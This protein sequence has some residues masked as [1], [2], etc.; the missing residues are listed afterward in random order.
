MG[1]LAALFAASVGILSTTGDRI[2]FAIEVAPP[3]PGD[4]LYAAASEQVYVALG[5]LIGAVA[6]PLQAASRTL[7]VRVAPPQK[8]TEF[9]GLYA[10]AGKVTSFLGPTA[11]GAVTAWTMSQRAGMAVLLVFFGLGAVLLAMVRVPPARAQ[12]AVEA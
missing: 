4:G 2:F 9:F 12:G 10:L 5:L 11:V 8:I 1:T 6:G 3:A 7:M